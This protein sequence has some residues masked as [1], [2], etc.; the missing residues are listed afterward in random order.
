MNQLSSVL[1]PVANA[2]V[3]VNN[4]VK[5]FGKGANE[6]RAI[7]GVSVDIERGK[8]TAVMGPSGCGKSTLMHCMVGLEKATSGSVLL[9]GKEVTQLK[10]RQL[11]K[12]RRDDVG[13]IFQSF[14]LVPNLNARENIELPAN[15]AGR[16]IDQE[17]FEQVVAA[18]GLTERLMHRP[19]EL[20]GGQQQRVACARAMIGKPAIV[21]ADEPTGNLDSK[22]TEQVLKFLRDSV[23]QNGQTVVM[24]THEAEAAA[25]ADRVLFLSD[26]KIIGEIID[27]TREAIFDV[28]K[29][30]E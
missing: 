9:N 11:T 12:L 7:D 13:F 14:N 20:S 16:K 5:V 25:I 26:G 3:S 18:L 15:I 10:E 23:K 29:T 28:L 2:V 8:L 19:A 17:L 30:F 27:P 4:L 21:F 24:V 22:A 6:V 1:N